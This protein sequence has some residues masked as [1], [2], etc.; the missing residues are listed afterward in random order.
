VPVGDELAAV[1]FYS[2]HCELATLSNLH[3]KLSESGF[4]WPTAT[5]LEG[6]VAAI[7]TY[8]STVQDFGPFEVKLSDTR[9]VEAPT[10]QAEGRSQLEGALEGVR[11]DAVFPLGVPL[12]E[13]LSPL[14]HLTSRYRVGARTSGEYANA[15]QLTPSQR[16]TRASW[17]CLLP[18]CSLR[19]SPGILVP[20]SPFI[21]GTSL[22][23]PREAPV[24][25][26]SSS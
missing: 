3:D 5:T 10:P 26:S 8:M 6:L 4:T 20:G 15:L 16:T 12:G 2:W 24:C 23:G 9:R 7:D 13:A 18:G 11:T 19:P 22:P 25:A 1:P 17:V 14:F 21:S